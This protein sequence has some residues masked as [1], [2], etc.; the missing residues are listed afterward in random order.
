MILNTKIR[1]I[2]CKVRV[3]RYFVQRPMG[4]M[5]DS[6]EDC[7]GYTEVDFDVLDRRGRPAP[8]LER[9]M[10]DED[11]NAIEQEVTEAKQVERDQALESRAEDLH[12]MEQQV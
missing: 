12:F 6:P 2:P 7:Y 8:W 3:T 11:R 1:G 9:K 4:R 5:A 10:L